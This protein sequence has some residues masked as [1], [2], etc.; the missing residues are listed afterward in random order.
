MIH[1]TP[2]AFSLYIMLV[3]DNFP[4]KTKNTKMKNLKL[5][6]GLLVTAT[7]LYSCNQAD[8]T[9]NGLTEEDYFFNLRDY[10]EQE[11]ARLEKDRPK[12]KK[13]IAINENS[14][15]VPTDTIDYAKELAIFKN[16]DINRVAWIDKYD[17]DTLRT[18]G[19]IDK[20]T[21]KARQKKLRTRYIVIDFDKGEPT[22]IKIQNQTDSPVLKAKQD[23]VYDPQ[24]GFAIIQEQKVRALDKKFL[25]IEVE[26]L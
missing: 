20:I 26:Y 7:L 18:N 10:M 2:A 16:S 22:R 14:E 17:G 3:L 23:L 6:M 9:D 15:E 21:Y 4:Q 24:D 12:V 19:V 13:V 11:I 1:F 8:V 5:L 25:K